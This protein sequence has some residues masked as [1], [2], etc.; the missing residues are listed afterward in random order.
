MWAKMGE[1]KQGQL[2]VCGW[3]D[4]RMDGWI[5]SQ[6]GRGK[7]K[8]IFIRIILQ[9]RISSGKVAQCLLN[10]RTLPQ[11]AAKLE[12]LCF[13]SVCPGNPLFKAAC[14]TVVLPERHCSWI[15]IYNNANLCVCLCVC[16][17]CVSVLLVE[18][19]WISSHLITLFILCASPNSCP[20][21]SRLQPGGKPW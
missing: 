7:R 10:T 6:R 19:Q 5:E 11:E 21:A 16:V 2:F 9:Q 14:Y 17:V 13:T 20:P 3:T 8:D 1:E 12:K 4:E 15:L 18:S